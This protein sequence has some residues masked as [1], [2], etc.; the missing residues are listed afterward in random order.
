MADKQ[1][2]LP[3][4]DV[5]GDQGQDLEGQNKDVKYPPPETSTSSV[6]FQQCNETEDSDNRTVQRYTNKPDQELLEPPDASQVNKTTNGEADKVPD[7]GEFVVIGS[8][9]EAIARQLAF[10]QTKLLQVEFFLYVKDL[11]DYLTTDAVLYVRENGQRKNYP[12]RPIVDKI[13]WTTKSP[14]LLPADRDTRYQYGVQYKAKENVFQTFGK[15]LHMIKDEE[16]FW[17]EERTASTH[18]TANIHRDIFENPRLSQKYKARIEFFGKLC[19]TENI[20]H[21]VRDR[22][23]KERLLEWEYLQFPNPSF[24]PKEQRKVILETITKL[25]KRANWMQLSFLCVVLGKMSLQ[26][27]FYLEKLDFTNA[28]AKSLLQ[29]LSSSRAEDIPSS[30][31]SGLEVIVPQLLTSAKQDE[32]WLWLLSNCNKLFEAS[33]LLQQATSK[34]FREWSK[35]RTP[36]QYIQHS[37]VAVYNLV[38]LHCQGDPNCHR[39]IAALVR[40]AP[41]IGTEIAIF[42]VVA[43][44]HHVENIQAVLEVLE[45][46]CLKS[47]ET[48][49]KSCREPRHIEELYHLW[50]KLK[51][52]RMGPLVHDQIATVVTQ[53]ASKS[54]TFSQT[55]A[56]KLWRMMTDSM[57]FPSRKAL[58]LFKVIATSKDEVSQSMF[59]ALAKDKNMSQE[60]DKEDAKELS[61]KWLR[62]AI[63]VHCTTSRMSYQPSAVASINIPRAYEDLLK[64]MAT[65]LV[66]GD[67]TIERALGEVVKGFIRKF[68]WRIM[69]KKC[70]DMKNMTEQA[71]G[72]YKEH[73]EEMIKQEGS[74]QLSEDLLEIAYSIC[75]MKPTKASAGLD[76]TYKL[77]EDLLV[78]LMNF[79]DLPERK[80][81][82]DL[83]VNYQLLLTVIKQPQFWLAILN[84]KGRTTRLHKHQR[85]KTVASVLIEFGEQ[86]ESGNIN[87][88]LFR[89]VVEKA[90][91][92]KGG[93]DVLALLID[94]TRKHAGQGSNAKPIKNVFRDIN[95]Q[96]DSHKQLLD[97]TENLLNVFTT[98]VEDLVKI[99]DI[100]RLRSDLQKQKKRFKEDRTLMVTDLSQPAYWGKLFDLQE[101]ARRLDGFQKS[102][103]FRNVLQ[104]HFAE[105]NWEED[106]GEDDESSEKSDENKTEEKPSEAS[107]AV[108]TGVNTTVSTSP[109]IPM[110]QFAKC[111]SEEVVDKFKEQC[112]PLTEYTPKIPLKTVQVMFS[113][114]TD[115]DYMKTELSC[116]DQLLSLGREIPFANRKALTEFVEFPKTQKKVHNLSAALQLFQVSVESTSDLCTALQLCEKGAVHD[117]SLS[118]LHRAVDKV[119]KIISKLSEEDNDIVEQLSRSSELLAF[120]GD[121]VDEDLRNL[122][123]AVEEHSEQFV[124]E[125][126]V[127]NLIDVK[128]YL[129]PL[130]KDNFDNN[131]ERFIQKLQHYRELSIRNLPEKINDCSINFHSLK[132]LYASVANRGEMT[133]EIAH[134]A[135]MK[136]QYTFDLN[137]SSTCKVT[138]SYDRGKTKASHSMSDLRDL[139]SRAL[140]IVNSDKGLAGPPE[141]VPPASESSAE[142][143]HFIKCIDLASSIAVSC[144]SLHSSG[145]FKYRT[146]QMSVSN[147]EELEDLDARLRHEYEN[148]QETLKKA[149]REHYYLNYLY[150]DQLWILDDFFNGSP[151]TPDLSSLFHFIH[152][153]I[154]VNEDLRKKYTSP[155]KGDGPYKRLCQI[156]SAMDMIC[157]NLQAPKREMKEKQKQQSPSTTTSSISSLRTRVQPGKVFVAALD[158]GSSQVVNIIMNLY[159]STTGSFPEPHQIIICSPDTKWGELHLLLQRCVGAPKQ[160]ELGNCLFCIANVELL[161]SDIQFRLVDE[162]KQLHSLDSPFLM[163]LVCR[164]GTHHP[165][166]DQFS[167]LTHRIQGMSDVAMRQC[168]SRLWPSVKM[169][170]SDIPGLGK[171]E[172]V[173]E[174]ASKKDMGVVSFPLGGT[175][176]RDY[177]VKRLSNLKIQPYQVL[178]LDISPVDDPHLLD[179]F[180]FE[181]I[182]VGAVHS[183]T[184]FVQRPTEYIIMEVANTL[185]HALRNTLVTSMCFERVHLKW[186]N[187]QNFIIS[188]EVNSPVQVVCHYLDALDR[189]TIDETDIP[190]SG[191]KRVTP[192]PAKRCKDLL[193]KYF[194]TGADLSFTIVEIFLSVLADQLKKFSASQYFRTANLRIMLGDKQEHQV[195]RNLFTA[196]LE[197]SK[198]FASRSVVSCRSSQSSAMTKEQAVQKLKEAASTTS[199]AMQMVSRVEGMIRWADS[200]HLMVIFHSQDAQTVSA[201]YR[202]LQ[203]VPIRIQDLF[204]QQVNRPLPEFSKLTQDELQII[205]ERIARSTSHKLKKEG[206]GT[207]DRRYALTPDNLLKMALVIMRVRARIPVIIMGETG[208]GKTSLIRYLAKT[209][210]VPFKVLSIH[211]GVTEDKITAFVTDRAAEARKDLSREV[212]AFLDE[213]N[214]C[215]HLGLINEII[216]HHSMLGKNLPENLILLAACN[217]YRQRESSQLHTAGLEGKARVDEYSKLVYR[218][219]P[220]PESM[221][222]YVWDYGTLDEKDER[223]YI[224]KMVT[225]VFPAE[226]KV[227]SAMLVDLLASS[228]NFI[229]RVEGNQF[230]VSLRDVNRCRILMG[231]F[232]NMLKTKGV[233]ALYKQTGYWLSTHVSHPCDDVD[234]RSVIL[235]LAH[236][237]HSR[238]ADSENRAKYRKELSEVM[239]R[240]NVTVTEHEIEDVIHREQLDLL[241]RMELPEGTAKNGALCENVFVLLVCILNRIPVFVVGKPGCSKSLSM[242]LIRSNLRGRDS[243]NKYFKELPQLYVVS[244]QGSESS[245][246]E[247]IIKVFDKAKKYKEHNEGGVLP[248]VLL[249]EIGLAEESRFNPLKVLHS[250][251]EPADDEFP[252]VAVVGISNWALDAAKMNRAV[253]LS[254]PEPD[255][256]D[257][258][259]TG[260]SLAEAALERAYHGD[261]HLT[262]AQDKALKALAEAYFEYEEKQTYKNFHG[263]R[264]YY[265]LIKCI[266]SPEHVNTGAVV[267]TQFNLKVLKRGLLRNFGGLSTERKTII[268][269]FQQKLRALHIDLDEDAEDFDVKQLIQDN[270]RDKQARHLMLITS[271]DS[272]VGILEQMI[273]DSEDLYCREQVTIFGSHL[274]DDLSEDYDY[275][276]L[277]RIILCMERGCIL[278][279]RDL[280][281]IYGSLYDMLNQNY[282]VVGKKRNCRVALGAYS[283]PMCQVHE[284]F[285]CIVLIDQQ[286]VNYS[287]PPFLNRFEKQLLR[288]SDVINP[289]QMSLIEKLQCW[290]DGIS[291]VPGQQFTKEDLFIG[292]HDDTLPSLVLWHSNHGQNL[293]QKEVLTGCK[294]DLMWIASPDGMLRASKS[295][296]A[297]TSF[298]DIV[299]L[300]EEYFNQPTHRGLQKFLE[301]MLRGEGPVPTAGQD[302]T[303][304]SGEHP[305][306]YSMQPPLLKLVI[307]TF[308]NVHTDIEACLEDFINSHTG[309]AVSEGLQVE[310]LSAF[311]S[312]KQLSSTIQHF[313]LESKASLLILQCSPSLDGPHMLLAKSQLDHYRN[314]YIKAR[315]TTGSLCDKHV[316][317]LIHVEQGGEVEENPWQLNF[318]CGWQQVTLDS[319]EEPTLPIKE[320]LNMTVREVLESTVRPFADVAREQLMWCFTCFKYRNEGRPVE[321]I[322]KL[323]SDISDSPVLMEF[324][325]QH[326]Y[327]SAPCFSELHQEGD[328][329]SWQVQVACDRQLLHSCSGLQTAMQQFISLQ[330]RQPLA[331]AIFLIESQSAWESFFSGSPEQQSVWIDLAQNGD[332]LNF[333]G[334]PEPCGP[335]S[336]DLPEVV[337][338]LKFPFCLHFLA[339]LEKQKDLFFDEMRQLQQDEDNLDEDGFLKQKEAELQVHRFVDIVDKCIPDVFQRSALC[340]HLDLL[341]DD[342]CNL[343]S[344]D[345]G[346]RLETALRTK[347]LGW[348]IA[349]KTIISKPDSPQL[350]ITDVVTCYWRNSELFSNELQLISSCVDVVKLDVLDLLATMMSSESEPTMAEENAMEAPMESLNDSDSDSFIEEAEEAGLLATGIEATEEPSEQGPETVKEEDISVILLTDEETV[351]SPP[352]LDEDL[353]DTE[354]ALHVDKEKLEVNEQ[355]PTTE[356]NDSEEEEEEEEEES[357]ECPD[358]EFE[359]SSTISERLVEVYCT[360]MLPEKSLIDSCGGL[361]A[362]HAKVTTLL[363][364]AAKVSRDTPIFHF[365]RLCNDL[366]TTLNLASGEVSVMNNLAQ[367]AKCEGDNCMNSQPMFSSVVET[368][369]NLRNSG[370]ISSEQLQQFLCLLFGRC[371]DANPDTILIDSILNELSKLPTGSIRYAGPVLDRILYFEQESHQTQSNYPEHLGLFQEII[372]DQDLALEEHPPLQSL[373]ICLHSLQ[374]TAGF[375]SHLATLCSDIIQ[376][377]FFSPIAQHAME[378]GTADNLMFDVLVRAAKVIR[379]STSCDLQF[380]CSV[381]FIRAF[382][383]GM[384]GALQEMLAIQEQGEEMQMSEHLL[385]EVNTQLFTPSPKEE[386][387]LS[388]KASM[389]LFFLKQLRPDCGLLGLR[390]VS[391]DLGPM[392]PALLELEWEKHELESRFPFGPLRYATGYE[393]A[394]KA[395]ALLKER[396]DGEMN[397]LIQKAKGCEETRFSLLATLYDFYFLVRTVRPARDTEKAAAQTIAKMI[398]DFPRPY[399]QALLCT[400]GEQDSKLCVSEQSSLDDILKKSVIMHLLCAL[401]SSLAQNMKIQSPFQQYLTN[402]EKLN[403]PYVLAI[404]NNDDD[405]PEVYT[406]ANQ[407]MW[408]EKATVWSCSCGFLVAQ[409]SLAPTSAEQQMVCP[410]C[411]SPSVS[412]NHLEGS[413][414]SQSY[415]QNVSSGGTVT[416]QTGYVVASP[417]ARGGKWFTVRQLSPAAYRCLH[418]L[419][420]GCLLASHYAEVCKP[421]QLGE[422]I[423]KDHDKGQEAIDICT[424]FVDVDWKALGEV[425]SGTSED[426][427]RLLHS[428]I[429]HTNSLLNG[430]HKSGQNTCNTREEREKLEEEFSAFVDKLVQTIPSSLRE[431][432][433]SALSEDIDIEQGPKCLEIKV[434]ELE[435]G[436]N[437]EYHHDHALRLFRV[438]EMRTFEKLH[439]HF[440]NGGRDLQDAY[441][442][443]G[444]FFSM[445]EQLPYIKHLHPLLRWTTIVK[446]RLSHRLA[447]EKAKDMQICEFI[448]DSKLTKQEKEHLKKSFQEFKEAWHQLHGSGK[449][450]DERFATMP[451]MHEERPIT[452]CLLDPQIPDS[453]LQTAISVLYNL[454]NK[455]LTNVAKLAATTTCPAVSF[456]VREQHSSVIPQVSILD[457]KKKDVI[458]YTWS[459]EFMKHSECNTEY[460]LGRQLFFDFSKIEMELANTLVLGK[461]YINDE[462]GLP[463]FA[464]ANELFSASASILHDICNHVPQEP[465]ATDTVNALRERNESDRIAKPLLEHM[466]VVL[467]LLKRTKG[468]PS[469]PLVDYTKKWLSMLTS[470]FPAHLLPEPHSAIQLKNVVHLYETLE[471]MMADVTIESLHDCFRQKLKSVMQSK[472]ENATTEELER[473]V[474][475]TRQFV[476]R[477]MSSSDSAEKVKPGSLLLTHLVNTGLWT[478]DQKET[479]EDTATTTPS[480][481]MGQLN[482]EHV[483]AA[484]EAMTNTIGDRR[485]RERN[486]FQSFTAKKTHQTPSRRATRKKMRYSNT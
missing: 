444:L 471:D 180:I 65:E 74:A 68:G 207:L 175:I 22:N 33:Y 110:V 182:V 438:T 176:T 351:T 214:T 299:K 409:Q 224:T 484:L 365:L 183:G 402:P 246:S 1:P 453:H 315:K 244:H 414:P 350:T 148:W 76:I 7:P 254:R 150:S 331:K 316:C 181:L 217:P 296:L 83:T 59:L 446:S 253:H 247:G 306:M 47:I 160:P 169:V 23:L 63:E 118:E 283:N 78:M 167:R 14:V 57:L 109:A 60:V 152:P 465:L 267:M 397:A 378:L 229:R 288:F 9:Q 102:Y 286:K 375:D 2:L 338:D 302:T 131:P 369:R 88:Q 268:K 137:T 151:I 172:F 125:S 250:L 419:V 41:D 15:K 126:T 377:R 213:I 159:E 132:G 16:A 188:P 274:D 313:W 257:L 318:L 34:Q 92:V 173:Q 457:V 285:R 111:L 469:E 139:R 127:S 27:G 161:Q 164:G 424:K 332:M 478:A 45:S 97:N 238:L 215:D 436:V 466:E 133:K 121:V 206:T 429:Q 77:T 89:A 197:V 248:V 305:D 406:A 284:N 389:V 90:S 328:A 259:L 11:D 3:A 401:S 391:K 211:A 289:H 200:N 54:Y 55:Q 168:F 441:P 232:V 201:L 91:D 434:E 171:T 100:S 357:H 43:E 61:V 460:G 190:L 44:Y 314:E 422:F 399:K 8:H 407:Q 349:Q 340:N 361:K 203:Q 146:F 376:D 477:Y 242:Q 249:D 177:M 138:M 209:C 452:E 481:F 216:C 435:R 73:L 225:G 483:Y 310:K 261:R 51:D 363:S 456:L 141:E 71:Q 290:V 343:M 84:A 93:V 64:I 108:E 79:V 323:V 10:E 4:A 29:G 373:N 462:Q 112:Q 393:D 220:L 107:G 264:D 325:K 156:G 291:T 122:I 355:T 170:T 459:N 327:T 223:S 82:E 48:A 473:A 147:I 269:T 366:A 40:E 292:F 367:T 400:V 319:I 443:L 52:G 233:K 230:G 205:L 480:T 12:L 395:L 426:V 461:A 235:T 199:S 80:P 18:V 30:C 154:S 307:H 95:K 437:R 228:Q 278:I 192:L 442:F 339:Q 212:W 405:P 410:V 174:Q 104:K 417:E 178:H 386:P 352:A 251:L 423:F 467:F 360:A 53:L 326:V 335:E 298:P 447:K 356:S 396:D 281:S 362:W 123:D 115:A 194:S 388:R 463:K 418:L 134:N 72:L 142:L 144:E 464:Y 116:L 221:L 149:R 272:A 103:V 341:I 140:L 258:Y 476:F 231:W 427:C 282:T 458:H 390:D 451:P 382:L 304:E 280:D 439:C 450:V 165:I 330:V 202:S 311:K 479:S 222:D 348:A 273:R 37:K 353:F 420:H 433:V 120:L 293:N 344:K 322:L 187:Y 364:L 243:S 185:N 70:E 270:L 430:S 440:M 260:K 421:E 143:S 380:I 32:P 297:K 403:A 195:R 50:M 38:Q 472:M 317:L 345:H 196:L 234:V 252:D 101:P 56:D 31:I 96:L 62:N 5:E 26:S 24:T 301:H 46:N 454:Q 432:Q 342:F 387:T 58:D 237:Y 371:L 279:L 354:E 66:G 153:S 309:M 383:T 85:C 86:L 276:T 425:I 191:P 119:E 49:I 227:K 239:R 381:A 448:Y 162:I 374:S 384:A 117:T 320:L 219:H 431:Q 210:E 204:K 287:D 404:D 186:E 266:C 236:C 415:I 413:Q 398:S 408:D 312:E 145:H 25:S 184:D 67:Q 347:V 428:V 294:A 136:G 155:K 329:D 42:E 99:N 163:A 124:N 87:I 482:V 98:M 157:G 308:S 241:D 255:T 226:S 336:C 28:D 69:L 75:D 475:V 445:H 321:D 358:G 129:Q 394:M 265:S 455:F 39:L 334:C 36:A 198:E 271:G 368:A 333:D 218:V 17:I 135:Y 189:A 359:E 114:I 19:F 13:L 94:A 128:R 208:C 245:T 21:G 324:L 240:H 346:S 385:Q 485:Q 262:M 303:T 411:K 35:K 20:F 193:R 474:K 468:K 486:M 392:L 81:D 263:L 370:K 372:E 337:F 470:P 166:L 277:S 275:R 158:V 416:Q 379:E 179:A 106:E 449:A 113:G 130:L 6:Q 300:Q 105:M 295:S 412:T 256:K